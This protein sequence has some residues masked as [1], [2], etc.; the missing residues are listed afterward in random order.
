MCLQPPARCYLRC[1]VKHVS[2]NRRGGGG[3]GDTRCRQDWLPGC[4]LQ[5]GWSRVECVFR[6][7]TEQNGNIQLP[8]FPPPNLS[9]LCTY[10]VSTQDAFR[11]S[12]ECRSPVS[13]QC[14]ELDTSGCVNVRAADMM[15][16]LYGFKS[17]FIKA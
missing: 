11:R 13:W 9:T 6:R 2:R 1:G 17:F 5:S 10:T 7:A 3:E 4:P 15:F 14:S 16:L 8:D 12:T